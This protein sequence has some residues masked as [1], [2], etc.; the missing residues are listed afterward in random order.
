MKVSEQLTR[1]I[2]AERLANLL[3]FNEDLNFATL[4]N[5]VVNLLSFLRSDVTHIFRNHFRRIK[6]VVAKNRV[7]EGHHE[8][9]F[10]CLFRLDRRGLLSNL[11]SKAIQ[12][13]G[14]IHI[15]LVSFKKPDTSANKRTEKNPAFAGFLFTNS[16]FRSTALAIPTIKTS[17]AAIHNHQRLGIALVAHGGTGREAAVVGGVGV[18][19]GGF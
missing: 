18:G 2:D 12:A 3:T 13:I 4:Q 1:V 17:L 9:I 19:V 8:C 7:Y 16:S 10:R 11:C 5:G 6:N 15:T 14:K